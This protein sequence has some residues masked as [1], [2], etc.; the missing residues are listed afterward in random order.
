MSEAQAVLALARSGDLAAAIARG[1]QAMAAGQADAGLTMFVGVLCCR[2]GDLD[3]GIAHLR[4]AAGLAPDQPVP[5]LELARALLSAG[6]FDEAETTAASLIDGGLAVEREATRIRA[7]A[8]SRLKRIEQA[9]PLFER[10]VASDPGDFE[11]WAGLGVAR[12]AQQDAHGAEDALERALRL[13]PNNAANVIQLARARSL[14]NDPEAAL[15]AALRAIAL[16]PASGEARVEAA[17]AG[18]SLRD[19]ASVALHLEAARDLLRDQAD[20]LCDVGD[21]AASAKMLDRAEADYRAA[22]TLDQASDRGWG[23]LATVLERLNRADDLHRVIVEAR[24]AGAGEAALA[25]AR[26][27]TL[28]SEGR[29]AEALAA[30]RLV[31]DDGDVVG[32]EQ[33]IGDTLDRMGDTA[34]AFAAFSRANA[35]LA[36]LNAGSERDAEE[37]RASFERLGR[38]V[39]PAWYAD[40][41]APPPPSARPAPLFL[42]GFPRSGTTLIDTMLGGHEDAVVLEEEA[43]VDR[44]AAALG[45]LDHL[46]QLP[47]SEIERLREVYFAEVDRIVPDAGSRLIVDKQPLALGST[48]ILHRI[49][50]DAR[51]LFA[52]RHPCDVVLSCFITSPQM[53]AKV[54]NFFDFDA[55]ARLYDTVLRYWTRCTEVLALNVMATRYERLIA[56]PA[57]ELRAVAHFAGLDWSEALI[58]NRRHAADRGFIASPSY[59]QVAQPIYQR[60]RGRWLRYR[61]QMAPV[62]P[63]LLPW[64]ERMGYPAD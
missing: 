34:A 16:D 52:E 59:A 57:R 35:R 11:S 9:L 14:R 2:A 30:A 55:T 12:L 3:A 53:D 40:W 36:E 18:A 23:G 51:F 50:P 64:A 10:L 29:L 44:V 19:F 25:L 4:V 24:A 27:R 32:R 31:P 61:E 39:S 5:A 60:A 43:S 26:A 28:R 22:L 37:Y 49:F 62:L 45:A 38:L 15:D 56:D 47:L 63:L 1:E 13:R 6:R 7:L 48:P 8:L 41:E 21:I 42:F 20:A 58:D 33:V 54:A 17:R 46:G